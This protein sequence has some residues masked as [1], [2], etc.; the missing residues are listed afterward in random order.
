MLMLLGL[1]VPALS[2]I[3]AQL[4]SVQYEPL[5][6]KLSFSQAVQRPR[7]QI[8]LNNVNE[9]SYQFI[10]PNVTFTDTYYFKTTST[11]PTSSFGLE[12]YELV[13]NNPLIVGDGNLNIDSFVIIAGK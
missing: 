9:V 5:I 4:V 13:F 2:T 3:S 6:F 1:V 10:S 8:M 7:F 11:P 12:S